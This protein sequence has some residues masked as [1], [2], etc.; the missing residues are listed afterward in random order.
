MKKSEERTKYSGEPR[1]ESLSIQRWSRRRE[2]KR[3]RRIEKEWREL[4]KDGKPDEGRALAIAHG[5]DSEV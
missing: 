5:Y 1:G 3:S 2:R 4:R